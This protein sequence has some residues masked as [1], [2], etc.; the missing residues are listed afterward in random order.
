MTM[1]VT[2]T[3]NVYSQAKTQKCLNSRQKEGMFPFLWTARTRIKLIFIKRG[4]LDPSLSWQDRQRQSK[5]FSTDIYVRVPTIYINNT[6]LNSTIWSRGNMS[7]MQNIYGWIKL[8][9][10]LVLEYIP[11]LL[12]ISFMYP[13]PNTKIFYTKLF[14]TMPEITIKNSLWDLDSGSAMIFS[15]NSVATAILLF[16]SMRHLHENWVFRSTKGTYG[17]I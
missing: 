9:K 10:G 5:G 12:P 3:A 4:L 14:L 6:A 17:C 2:Q 11:K 13:S 8:G 16:I 1:Q 7:F 15:W